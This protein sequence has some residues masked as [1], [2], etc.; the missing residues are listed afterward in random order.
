[1]V[2]AVVHHK[3]WFGQSRTVALAGAVYVVGYFL[4]RILLG[5]RMDRAIEL[6]CRR[7]GVVLAIIYLIV[8]GILR[9]TGSSEV[10][11]QPVDPPALDV[12]NWIGCATMLASLSAWLSKWSIAG[13]VLVALKLRNSN[14]DEHDFGDR[15][16]V[17]LG[18]LVCLSYLSWWVGYP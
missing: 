10:R 12:V 8:W 5:R 6:L 2:L 1:M 14:E 16:A 17:I 11:F 15:A 18:T 7:I 4:A 9:A 13:R 3:V